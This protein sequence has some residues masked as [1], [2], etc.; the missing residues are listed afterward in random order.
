QKAECKFDAWPKRVFEGTVTQI[1]LNPEIVSNVVTYTVV[2]KVGNAEMKL[3]PGMTANVT[4]VTERRDDV[5][6]I[7]AAAL[8][9]SPPVD[10]VPAEKTTDAGVASPLGMPRFPRGG[11]GTQA[12]SGEQVVWLVEQGRLA[13]SLPVGDQGISDRTWVEIMNSHLME[14]QELAVSFSKETSA[15]GVALAGTK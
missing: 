14:G 3:K 11:S 12:R 1:R 7:P 8:R 13:G 4:I 10:A 2:L 15:S 6:K 9:F 5:L